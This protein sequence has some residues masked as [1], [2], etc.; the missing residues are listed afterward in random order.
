[1]KPPRALVLLV[2]AIIAAAPAS[3]VPDREESRGLTLLLDLDSRPA[4][5]LSAEHEDEAPPV[6]ARPRR[7]DGKLESALAAEPSGSA[8]LLAFDG[9]TKDAATVY[10]LPDA[11]L[12]FLDH[13]VSGR[14]D[15]GPRD[16]P[17]V[18]LVHLAVP[19]G[20][21]HLLLGAARSAP[22]RKEGGGV[23]LEASG[24]YRLEDGV[25][26][27]DSPRTFEIA[28]SSSARLVPRPLPPSSAS[29]KYP[30]TCIAGCDRAPRNS[31]D[32]VVL[33]DGYTAGELA[34]LRARVRDFARQLLGD[35]GDPDQP[36]MP[37]FSEPGVR[38]LVSIRLVEA[39]SKDRHVT[40]CPGC[41]EERET[42]FR[43][44][45]DFTGFGIAS[46]F[47]T[48]DPQSVEQAVRLVGRSSWIEAR[49]VVAN[50]EEYGGKAAP[51]RR[52]SF[53]AAVPDLEE[54][55]HLAVHEMAHSVAPLV[56]EYLSCS[57]ERNVRRRFVNVATPDQVRK[58]R[59]PWIE[60]AEQDE[61]DASAG[62]WRVRH[63]CGEPEPTGADADALGLFWGA[64]FIEMSAM[65]CECDRDEQPDSRLCNYYRSMR[66]C[67]MLDVWEGFCRTCAHELRCAVQR[68]A[69][70]A[71]N[72]CRR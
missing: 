65:P 46:D 66:V 33:G 36:G 7:I 54:F 21:R 53:V 23:E 37:P 34:G 3:A 38:E 4:R 39:P 24:L 26:G 60:R 32:I 70:T 10:L 40:F 64:Q 49:L 47:D 30:V 12:S 9:G 63:E 15:G 68:A 25:E 2:A 50:C 28:A 8:H 1:M 57:V 31:F 51:D 19:A 22:G 48:D 43:V 16:G 44:R 69:G 42:A 45:G 27:D 58:G 20:A 35:P 11:G 13:R 55:A 29:P 14:L 71:P 61:Y 17:D 18:R 62:T 67:K 72:E 56:D 41:K 5:V 59:V 52:T 6:A